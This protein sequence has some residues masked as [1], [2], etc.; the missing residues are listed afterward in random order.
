MWNPKRWAIAILIGLYLYFLLPATA[1][2]F[3]ELYHLTGIEPV[4]WG[5]SA[6]KAGGYYFGIWEYRGLACLVVT[7]LIGLLSGIFA[8]SKT[9]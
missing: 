2:L 5:Y 1:V 9:A 3:Y 6:F 7:L 8:R 4:Y